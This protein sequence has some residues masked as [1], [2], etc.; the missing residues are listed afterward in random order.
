MTTVL[1]VGCGVM[2]LSSALELAQQGYHVTAIDAYPVPSPWSA[3]N[4]YNKIIRTEYSELMYTKMSIE[5]LDLWRS[6]PMFKDTFNECGRV[7]LTPKSYISRKEFEQVGIDNLKRVGV[8]KKIEIFRGGEELTSKFPIFTGNVVKNDEEFKWNPESGLAHAANSLRAVYANAKLL[9]VKFFFGDVGNAVRIE[10]VD[11]I[12]SVTT[13]DG[14]RYVADKIIVT[15]GASTGYLV[16]MKTQQAATGLFVT[17]IRVNEK[18]YFKY[19][20]MPVVFDSDMGYFFPPD[21]ETR[22]LKLCLPG[23]GAS[24]YVKDP[25]DRGEK[26]SLPRYKLQNP[27]DTIPSDE[28]ARAIALL[29]KFA[30]E[31]AYHNLFDHKVC[32]IADTSDSHFIVDEVPGYNQLYVA[33]GDSGH[34]FKFLPN[35]GKYIRKKLEGTLD[36]ELNYCWRWKS[37]A[38]AFNATNCTWR[39]VDRELDFSE[40]TFYD[41]LNLKF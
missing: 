11:G 17:H 36:P 13:V 23:S 25:F 8:G 15:M 33:T 27:G 34:A 14:T 26:K 18:E 10:T 3:A 38:T 6:S 4:D 5:A 19:K 16:D 2:G 35:I 28:P 24:N 29:R 20:D 9:G 22:I 21:P 32:W 1:I 31:L 12:D 39:V 30:P 40:I 7:M 37:D 41:E